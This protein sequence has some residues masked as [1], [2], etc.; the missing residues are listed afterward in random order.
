M[1]VEGRLA[2]LLCAPGP[3]Q[4]GGLVSSANP[5]RLTLSSSHQQEAAGSS[6]LEG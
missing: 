3:L 4:E 2:R 1:G 6:K 5:E